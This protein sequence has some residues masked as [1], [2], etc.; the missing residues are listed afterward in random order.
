MISAYKVRAKEV[1]EREAT[2]ST[3]AIVI[4]ENISIYSIECRL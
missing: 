3:T 2:D 1:Y 4:I